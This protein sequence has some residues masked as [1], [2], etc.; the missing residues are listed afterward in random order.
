MVE[1]RGVHGL[2]HG[3]VAA[4]GEGDI[5]DAARETRQRETRVQLAH[6]FDEGDAVVVVLLDAG[7]DGEDVRIEDDVS[8]IETDFVDEDAVGA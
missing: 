5:A 7:G 6:G 8:R 4:E 2:A 1:K 3:L